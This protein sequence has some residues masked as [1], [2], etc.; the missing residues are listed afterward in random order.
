M[1]FIERTLN[2]WRIQKSSLESISYIQNLKE[3]GRGIANIGRFFLE[4]EFNGVFKFLERV[5]GVPNA[6]RILQSLLE[7]TFNDMYNHP[8]GGRIRSQ[9]RVSFC[10]AL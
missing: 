8:G 1:A 10:R 7:S 4:S 6:R 9:T 2:I 3:R 5:R